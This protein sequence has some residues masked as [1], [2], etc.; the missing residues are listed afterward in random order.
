MFRIDP[1]QAVL[2]HVARQGATGAQAA[3]SDVA[4]QVVRAPVETNYSGAVIVGVAQ[5][6]EA[7]LLATLGLGIYGAYV[8]D[9]DPVFFRISST[10]HVTAS[11]TPDGQFLRVRPDAGFA[12]VARIT[13]VADDGF[14]ATGEIALDLTVSDAELLKLSFLMRDYGFDAAGEVSPIVVIG[15]FADQADVVL[16]FD[17]VSVTSSNP[18]VVRVSDTGLVTAIAEG[19]ARPTLQ[20]QLRDALDW[21]TVIIGGGATGLGPAPGGP[22]ARGPLRAVSRPGPSRRCYTSARRPAGDD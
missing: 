18:N 19:D 5:L 13:L 9:G 2:D 11:F 14:A 15:Q 4:D 3:L 22:H 12:G 6:L 1:K 16:P 8:A 20:R 7:L 17:Y 10:E 21:K